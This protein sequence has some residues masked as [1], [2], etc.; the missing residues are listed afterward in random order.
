MHI[1]MHCGVVHIT[2][3]SK[4]H[5]YVTFSYSLYLDR[6][7]YYFQ[8]EL[9]VTIDPHP[10][11]SIQK[12]AREIS[13]PR[14]PLRD[15]KPIRVSRQGSDPGSNFGILRREIADLEPPLHISKT[16]YSSK[17]RAGSYAWKSEWMEAE[18][19]CGG[20][21]NCFNIHSEDFFP[22]FFFFFFFFFFG[23]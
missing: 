17:V 15:F 1:S 14:G 7:T 21:L 3:F 11:K 8:V 19:E 22:M 16:R 6:V 20:E 5:C 13:Q 23:L 9:V 2:L 18:R 10:K 4:C 12:R